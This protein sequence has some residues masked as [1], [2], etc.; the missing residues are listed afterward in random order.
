MNLLDLILANR[1][2]RRFYQNEE[3]EETRLLSWINLARLSASARN[4][5]SLKYIILNTNDICGKVFPYLGWAGYLSDWIGPE[6]GERPSAYIIMLSDSRIAKEYFCDHGI[7]AQS[8]LLGAVN[9]GFG[10]CIV[11]NIQRAKLREAINLPE[12]FDIIQILALGK[13]KEKVVIEDVDIKNDIR[14]WRDKDRIHH[15]P[16][17]KLNDIIV[18]Y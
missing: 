15:V 5:Q 11:A 10:G 8:I 16:K 4:M 7:A 12:H 13:P 6:E 14:Y 3:I 1:S 17:R 18:K 2:Y 9:D